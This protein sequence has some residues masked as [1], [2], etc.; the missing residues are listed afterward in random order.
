MQW[1]IVG[2]NDWVHVTWK[3]L[4]EKDCDNRAYQA[5][6]L[7]SFTAA[8]TSP[9]TLSSASKKFTYWLSVV[10]RGTSGWV[11]RCSRL[12]GNFVN[13]EQFTTQEASQL[14]LKINEIFNC[15]TGKLFFNDPC[16]WACVRVFT[17]VCVYIYTHRHTQTLAIAREFSY[18][19]VHIYAHMYVSVCM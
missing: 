3:L 13:E 12:T 6:C 8:V 17:Y 14:C 11:L 18:L 4:L 10:L 19:S 16:L 9:I 15:K 7:L 1:S 5:V 2:A